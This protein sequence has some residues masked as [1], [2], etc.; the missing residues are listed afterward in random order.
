M[1]EQTNTM[2]TMLKID[3]GIASTGD[4]EDKDCTDWDKQKQSWKLYI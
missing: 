4:E 2:L 1:A 3:L